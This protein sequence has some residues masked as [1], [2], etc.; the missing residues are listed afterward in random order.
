[1]IETKV[2]DN[3]YETPTI[4]RKFALE[5]EFFKKPGNYPGLRTKFIDSID[6]DFFKVFA[7][8]LISL[9]YDLDNQNIKFQILTSFQWAGEKYKHGWIHKDRYLK[10]PNDDEGYDIAGVIYLTP[11]APTNC[12]TS[13][14]RLISDNAEGCKLPTDP[15]YSGLDIDINTYFQEQLKYNSQFEKVKQVEN[16]FNRLV[17]Y[18]CKQW[19]S[20]DGFF[21]DTAENSRLIQV[22]F[23]RIRPC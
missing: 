4:I 8:K 14:Y 17:V 21:G 16:I 1:M 2:I 22:F 10:S 13:L 23:A 19:H 7:K 12:G 3:F 15:F 6:D 18:D 11:N 20:Q 5:Q 9:Y